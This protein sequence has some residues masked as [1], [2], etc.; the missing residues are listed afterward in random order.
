VP[1]SSADTG[2]LQLRRLHEHGMRVQILDT[3]VDVDTIDTAVAVAELA[4]HTA[5]AAALNLVERAA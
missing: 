1:M 3:L 5:F 4:P 2:A